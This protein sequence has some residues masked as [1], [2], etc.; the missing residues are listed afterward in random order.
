[1]KSKKTLFITSSPHCFGGI[2]SV[3][4]AISKELEEEDI[5]VFFSYEETKSLLY[6]F[7]RYIKFLSIISN[8]RL[9][10]LNTPLSFNSFFRDLPYL[11]ISKLFNVNSI[12]HFH[13]G[14]D[15]FFKNILSNKLLKRIA[16]MTYFSSDKIIVLGKIFIKKYSKIKFLKQHKWCVL[17]NPVE[18]HIFLTTTKKIKNQPKKIK[19]L[20]LSR[21]DEKKGCEIAIKSFAA[22]K[23]KTS[24]INF[25]LN[26]CG[27]GPLLGDMKKLSSELQLKNINFHGYVKGSEKKNQYSTNDIFLYPTYYG[28]GL[29]VCVLEAMAMGLPIITRL[30]GGIGDFVKDGINGYIIKSK[31]PNDFADKIIDLVNDED[32]L[33]KISKH[34]TSYSKNTFSPKSIVNKYV[35]IYDEFE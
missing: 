29:P 23:L 35:G 28:E 9:I 18:S 1:M 30:V 6:F 20:F 15:Q 21:I 19:I 10:H 32:R 34:N 4:R 14:E 25:E 33:L 31:N 3:Y 11:I 8:Y 16:S 27:D 26:I 2:A 17:P 24:K 22:L 13:G 12:V 7:L 5:D